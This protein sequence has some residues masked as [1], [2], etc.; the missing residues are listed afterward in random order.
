MHTFEYKL[1]S[2]TMKTWERHYLRCYLYYCID[3]DNGF[4]GNDS[5]N[6][7]VQKRTL[8]QP[9]TFLV[10]PDHENLGIHVDAPFEVLAV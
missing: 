7:R 1:Q 5:I 3:I 4:L 10:I 2:L 6:H 9:A 8:N